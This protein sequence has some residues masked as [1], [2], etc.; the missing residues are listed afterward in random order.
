MWC[1]FIHCAFLVFSQRFSSTIIVLHPNV[2]VHFG[3]SIHANEHFSFE[4]MIYSYHFFF[5]FSWHAF[6]A[7]LCLCLSIFNSINFIGMCFGV[8][9]ARARDYVYLI[10]L[11]CIGSQ[12]SAKAATTT[13]T[14]RV[15][16]FRP[17]CDSFVRLCGTTVRHS[18][19]I[20]AYSPLIS[21]NGIKYELEKNIM[22]K[23]A[24]EMPPLL[25]T[26][27]L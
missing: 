18:R 22:W 10:E 25:N 26:Q 23:A 5:F 6:S 19:S 13:N 8:R 1:I 21:V 7:V 17:R 4:T 2:C 11:T 14:S 3:I 15:T 24:N 9:N 16:R 12:R 27:N 20:N